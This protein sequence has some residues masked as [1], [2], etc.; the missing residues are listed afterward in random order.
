MKRSVYS[1]TPFYFILFFPFFFFFLKYNVDKKRNDKKVQR[2]EECRRAF[3]NCFIRKGKENEWD[4][5][6][7]V[8]GGVWRNVPS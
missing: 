3:Q 5:M 7:M 8:S 2:M 1:H 4:V 6:I